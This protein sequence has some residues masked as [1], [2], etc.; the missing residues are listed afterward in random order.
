M[1]RGDRALVEA[2]DTALAEAARKCGDWLAC[3]PGCAECC[4][5]P[6]A[7]TSLDAL[8][9]RSGMEE[10]G[11]S[12]PERAGRVIGRARR[13]GGGEDEPCPALD[14]AT[15]L[16]DLYAFRPITCRAFGPPTRT[17]SGD[18][19][20]CERCF[21]GATEEQIAACEVD[22]DPEGIEAALLAQ[23]DEE[24]TVGQAI[25]LCDPFG[26]TTK[27]DRLSR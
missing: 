10:L 27:D 25:G 7:I 4:L 20:V 6:F 2:V 1:E 5:G 3:R 11:R 13:F 21:E 18:L 12:D 15:S 9:L 26:Q 16:C 17:E 8:R 22:L 23:S 24:T 14:P 19:A